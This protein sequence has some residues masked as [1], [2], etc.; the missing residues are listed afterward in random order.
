MLFL[1][2][3]PGTLPLSVF[4]WAGAFRLWLC[5]A[6]ALAVVGPAIVEQIRSRGRLSPTQ[7]VVL[8]GT[9]S[10]AVYGMTAYLDT[11]QHPGG[12]EPP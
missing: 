1:P 3:L 11:K 12:D 7:S 4:I 5:T 2:W 6:I 9:L 10:A 8:A